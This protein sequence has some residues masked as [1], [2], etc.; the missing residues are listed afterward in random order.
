MFYPC[1]VD[2]GD[3]KSLKQGLVVLTPAESRRLLAKAVAAL[4]EVKEAY[5]NGRLA[6]LSGGTTSFV[7]QEVTGEKLAPPSF[8]MGM[9]ADGMLTSSVED[10][11]VNGR[12]FV[13]GEKVDVF[14]ADFVK[15][16]GKGDAIV[17]GANAVDASGALGI[18]LSNENGGAVGSIFGPASARGIP[19]IAP[20]GLEKQV[21]SV[22]EAAQGWGQTTLDY[23][24]GI[25][26]GYS[27]L[28]NALVVTEIEALAFLAGVQARVVGCGGI[29]G[30]EG[31]VILL[32]EGTPENLEK[33]LQLVQSVKGEPKI[34]V[35]RHQLS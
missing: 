21:W 28:T 16:M 34:Q 31:A 19:I 23:S 27:V 20:V 9:S 15:T 30:N 3:H 13:A 18:L 17:K 33:A 32:L 4:P 11:R 22:A 14:Y 26:V 5:A 25:K 6:I 10:G 29:A 2:L 35:P 12:C 7:L 24:M 1:P 8:S